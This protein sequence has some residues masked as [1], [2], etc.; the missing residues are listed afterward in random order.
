MLEAQFRRLE[1][2]ET[3]PEFD[4]EA[5]RECPPTDLLRI[6]GVWLEVYRDGGW[7]AVDLGGEG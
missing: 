3:D 1:L 7:H 6:P 4:A 2:N 5:L